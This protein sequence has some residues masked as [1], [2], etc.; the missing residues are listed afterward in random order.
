MN[1]VIIYKTEE[2]G[3]AILCPSSSW[4]G[5]LEELAAKDVPENAEWYIVDSEEI[6][7]DT[8]FRKAWY[9]T[10][11]S[12]N[13]DLLK[14]KEIWLKKYR[15]VR[16]P[17]LAALDIEFMKAVELGDTSLQSE[18]AAEK[19]ALR[20]VTMIELPNTLE[21]IKSTWPEILGQNPFG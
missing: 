10:N 2:D 12:I 20:D 7:K 11:N 14:V 1:S 17:L 13:I 4:D 3:V 5:T 16:G 6:P 18:I 19:Q 8:I 15:T 9:F 21:G